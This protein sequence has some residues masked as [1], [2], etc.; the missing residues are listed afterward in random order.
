M[1]ALD[2]IRTLTARPAVRSFTNRPV[3]SEVLTQIIEIARWTGSARNRQ[4][5]RFI[6][7]RDKEHLEKLG[8]LGA[9]AQHI[10]TAPCALILLSADNGFQDTEFGRQG[11]PNGHSRR[12]RPAARELP[13]NDLPGGQRDEGS[14][15]AP[16][17]KRMAPTP[18]Y[19]TRL[20]G[21]S[22]DGHA[23]DHHRPTNYL[24]IIIHT[25]PV[26]RTPCGALNVSGNLRGVRKG[27]WAAGTDMISLCRASQLEPESLRWHSSPY[28]LCTT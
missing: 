25:P 17:G 1:E 15:I 23:S 10:V 7:V 8:T 19:I 26:S 9:Y 13:G 12:D 16:N 20:R 28:G 27:T 5:W 21:S 11:Q 2:L 14:N 6:A 4:P 24:R 3:P 18:R 22:P